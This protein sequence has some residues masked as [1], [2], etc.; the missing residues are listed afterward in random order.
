MKT[1][2]EILEVAPDASDVEIKRAYLQQVKNNPPDRDQEQFQLIHN[3]YET[4]KDNKSRISYA[5]FDNPSVD[6][7]ELIDQALVT[8]QTVQISPEQFNELLHAGIDDTTIQNAIP[9]P[10]KP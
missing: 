7:E 3:A 2:Y 5:L 9:N 4:V 6:F 1:P 8:E 10:Q